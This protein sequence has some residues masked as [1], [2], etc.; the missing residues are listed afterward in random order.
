[1]NKEQFFALEPSRDLYAFLKTCK[2]IAYCLV[3]MQKYLLDD[4]H[5]TLY[6][7]N[8]KDIKNLIND[9]NNNFYFDELKIELNGWKT[10]F[11]DP[12][13]GRHTLVISVKDESLKKLRDIQLS[14][15]GIANKYRAKN[16]LD[17][18]KGAN[19]ISERMKNSLSLYGF[20]FVGDIWEGHFTIASFEA[21]CYDRIWNKFAQ[22]TTPK[23]TIID[24]MNLY[25]IYRDGFQLVKSWVAE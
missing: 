13:T 25:N 6:V 20:P 14:L 17:R 21:S 7:N 4:P 18:Y 16:I 2:E 10:F 15:V 5:L 8:F 22:I 23:D 24:T 12:I 3:G 19:T 1:M 9:L 11:N